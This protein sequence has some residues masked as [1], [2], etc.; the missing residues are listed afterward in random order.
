MLRIVITAL[1]VAL[2][3][4]VWGAISSHVLPWPDVYGPRV[5]PAP[6][7]ISVSAPIQVAEEVPS[8]ASRVPNGSTFAPPAE[9]ERTLVAASSVWPVYAY[10][11][12]ENHFLSENEQLTYLVLNISLG[13]I[14]A[15]VV[16]VL[17]LNSREGWRRLAALCALGL[18]AILVMDVAQGIWMQWPRHY[19][20]VLCAD[21]LGAA[22]LA[23]GAAIV[24]LHF[25]KAESNRTPSVA[26]AGVAAQ[27]SGTPQP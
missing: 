12:D 13:V 21:H 7:P 15:L 18:A 3:L 24:V 17:G 26:A 5:M 4:N 22:V 10:Y 19:V 25:W 1:V 9:E 27:G 6:M 20:A 23:G 2:C 11:R 8:L 14:V 16:A